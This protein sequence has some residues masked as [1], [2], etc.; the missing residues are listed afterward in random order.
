[1]RFAAFLP[2][3]AAAAVF[4]GCAGPESKLGRG[5]SNMTEFARLGEMRRSMEQ[6]AIW[7][8]AE[9]VPTTGFLRGLNR[10]FARTGLGIYEVVTFPFPPYEPK[11]TPKTPLY[12]DPSV[13]TVANKNW[14]GLRLPEKQ[15]SPATYKPGVMTDSTFEPDSSVGFSSGDA[16]PAVPGS[17]FRTLKP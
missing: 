8:G 11:M 7:D 16:F 2:L 4:T 14:G 3:F 17:R 12:P 13:S 6:T 9:T 1:M 10:S 15:V 5:I